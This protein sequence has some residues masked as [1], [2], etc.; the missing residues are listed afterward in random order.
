MTRKRYKPMRSLIAEM[1]LKAR[2]GLGF[3]QL[4]DGLMERE[5]FPESEQSVR[6][7][8]SKMKDQDLVYF[9][10]ETCDCCK[11]DQNVYRL[12]DT[13]RITFHGG[14]EGERPWS[15]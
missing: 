6:V 7:T 13:G 14:E 15:V 4:M 1:L 11:R 3:W 10:R 12:T 5:V 2:A 9:E 8:L